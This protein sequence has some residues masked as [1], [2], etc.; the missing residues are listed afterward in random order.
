M[1][2]GGAQSVDTTGV[3]EVVISYTLHPTS[4]S[5]SC[6]PSTLV[7]APRA[8]TCAAT[9]TDIASNGATAPTGT[10][11]FTTGGEG[12]FSGGGQCTLAAA[13]GGSAGC[14]VTYTPSS[15]AANPSRTDTI[16][17]S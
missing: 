11:S 12:S 4:T 3:P 6:A 14:S 5:V 16:A 1:P 10:V 17:A 9:V 2:P 13:V 7:A 15:T 8:A